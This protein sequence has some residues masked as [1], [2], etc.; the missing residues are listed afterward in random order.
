MSWQC[1]PNIVKPLIIKCQRESY[2]FKFN[3]FYTN[4][5]NNCHT[6]EIRYEKAKAT[7]YLTKQNDNITYNESSMGNEGKSDDDYDDDDD[8][9]HGNYND[10][11]KVSRL[12]QVQQQCNYREE[13]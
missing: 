12:Q 1:R 3:W 4:G 13:G 11:Y 7:L 2:K 10:N 9:N 5:I 8:G 6:T